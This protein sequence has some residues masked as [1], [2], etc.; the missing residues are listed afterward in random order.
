MIVVLVMAGLMAPDAPAAGEIERGYELKAQLFTFEPGL[1]ADSFR[2]HGSGSIGGAGGSLGF[3]C[4]HAQR[5]FRVKI[6]PALREHRYGVK[7]EVT[8]YGSDTVTEATSYQVDLSDLKAT[9]LELARDDDGRVYV[10]NLTPGITV[11]DNTVRRFEPALIG[12][13]TWRFSN[14]TIILNDHEYLGKMGASGGPKA[15][16]DAP[17]VAKIEFSLLEFRDAEPLGELKNG[18]I[19]ITGEDGTTIEIYGVS[20]GISRASQMELKGRP[21]QVWV[22]WS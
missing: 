22:R 5:S 3:I 15:W 16:F 4:S 21:Y 10:L 8:P 20:N 7:V 14:S 17:G 9:G 6:L 19:K 2:F 1:G 12:L 18:R 11:T 13:E